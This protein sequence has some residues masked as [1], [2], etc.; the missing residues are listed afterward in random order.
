MKRITID[1]KEYTF[2]FTIEA[3]LYDECTIKAMESFVDA[4]AAQA[5][6][7]ENDVKGALMRMIESMAGVPQRALTFFYAGLLE[8]HG[9]N[10]DGSVPSKNAAKSLVVK[11]MKESEKNWY[12]VLQ[13]MTE[14]MVEDSFFDQIGLNNMM[15]KMQTATEKEEKKP[16]KRTTAKSSTTD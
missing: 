15:E 7:T 9:S 14:L 5:D 2:E 10:G 4:G 12:D 8:H 6:A 16:R 11:Y 3:T 1:G 13:E